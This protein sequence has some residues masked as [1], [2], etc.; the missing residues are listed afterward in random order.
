MQRIT[1]LL[2]FILVVITSISGCATQPRA[3]VYLPK[4]S[5]IGYISLI[6][7]QPVLAHNGF[8]AFTKEVIVRDENWDITNRLLAAISDPLNDNGYQVKHL[9]ATDFLKLKKTAILGFGWSTLDLSSIVAVEIERYGKEQGVDAIM[10]LAPVMHEGR[11]GVES[12]FYGYGL[13][14]N[15]PLGLCSYQPL[16]NIVL[17]VAQTSPPS[18]IGI[19]NNKPRL[20][21]I[22]I[23]FDGE[24]NELSSKDFNKAQE[25]VFNATLK[26]ARNALIDANLIKDKFIVKKPTKQ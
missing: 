1:L 5:T 23:E 13:L 19:D 10:I 21:E 20:S 25:P 2:S 3:E 11:G 9:P 16:D 18:L 7:T 12:S 8:T 24:F 26:N 22:S 15:C 17:L 14:R 4:G 6:D